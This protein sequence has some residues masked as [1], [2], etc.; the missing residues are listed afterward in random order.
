MDIKAIEINDEVFP[1][2]DSEARQQIQQLN[3]TIAEQQ[4][5]IEQLQKIGIT[6]KIVPIKFEKTLSARLIYTKIGKLVFFNIY[7]NI[8][9][10]SAANDSQIIPSGSLPIPNTMELVE[11]TFYF[12]TNY[13]TLGA[14][15][16]ILKIKSDGSMTMTIKQQ[17]F[18]MTANGFYLAKEN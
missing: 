13:P 1:V 15:T 2:E 14:D 8:Q 7:A 11:P 12:Q 9:M 5:I 6:Q 4:N 17:H 10:Q 18:T 16:C 3:T